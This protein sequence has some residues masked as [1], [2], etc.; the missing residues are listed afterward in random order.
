M[1][2]LAICISSLE[3]CPFRSSA[4]F[5]IGFLFFWYWEAW[6]ACIFWRL[7]L[8]QLLRLQ[9]FS[10]ILRAV[11]W[12]CLWVS[13]AVQKL[14]SLIRSHLFIFVFI[15]ITL[16]GGSKRILLQ[17]MSNS[18][19][20]FLLFLKYLFIYFWLCSVFTA[21]RRLSLVAVSRGYSSLRCSGFSLQWLLLLWSTGF[22]RAGFSS[23]GSWALEH[24]LCSCG[25]WA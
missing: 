17:F 12:S 18:G 3:K 11:F 14:S 9:I 7:I 16:G 19:L 15:F 21:V 5:W 6:A 4:H 1:C 8:C 25:T 22:R 23:C 10:P 20:C 13:F 24:R 2:L